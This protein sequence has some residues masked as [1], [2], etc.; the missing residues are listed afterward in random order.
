M[1]NKIIAATIKAYIVSAFSAF[2]V[3]VVLLLL[4]AYDAQ[5][6]VSVPRELIGTW[7]VSKDG[8]ELVGYGSK[9]C[10]GDELTVTVSPKG[11]ETNEERGCTFTSTRRFYD[12]NV[13]RNTK[14]M[15]VNVVAIEAACRGEYDK[16]KET[17]EMFLSQGYLTIRKLKVR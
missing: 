16:W 13:P 3:M 1:S 10:H 15:G 11:Y 9:D 4:A 14:E 8:K 12:R 2:V 7:C 5:A 17:F 6:A